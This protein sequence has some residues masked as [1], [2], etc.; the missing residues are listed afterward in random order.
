VVAAA[1]LL[2]LLLLLSQ[3][4]GGP[5]EANAQPAEKLVREPAVAGTFYPAQPDELRQMISEFLTKARAPVPDALQ[6]ERPRAVVVPHAGYMFSGQTAAC[7]Y[8]L[9]VG[10]PKPARVVLLGPS[11]YAQLAGVVSVSPFTHYR[12]PLGEIAVDVEAREQLLKSPLCVSK[13]AVHVPEHSIEVQ[14]PFLQVVW[15][16]PPRILP[17]VT[18]DL[19]EKQV[20]ELAAAL[21]GV[22]GA[23]ALIVAS[24]DFTHYGPRFAFTPFRDARGQDLAARIRQLDMGAV[25]CIKNCDAAGFLDYCERTG[26]TICGRVPIAVTLGVLCGAGQ[27]ESVSLRY[28]SSGDLTGDYSESVSYYAHAFYLRPPEPEP[29][30]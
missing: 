14:L 23:D 13:R 30:R 3:H 26:A 4:R 12:T 6:D 10:R 27:T 21:R 11:H 15:E 24:S 5:Q 29:Q 8:K 19:S 18:G 17:I 20:T 2:Y 22:A 1:A 28:A 9:L 25:E 7:A 16:E